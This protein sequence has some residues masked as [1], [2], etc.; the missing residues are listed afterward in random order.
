VA[1]LPFT[2]GPI[3]L[4]MSTFSSTACS[5][6]FCH[7]CADSRGLLHGLHL[8]S[9]APSNYQT[10][11]ARKHVGPTSTSTGLNSVLNS[12]STS[13]YDDLALSALQKGILEIEPNG[14]RSL[15]YQSTGNLGTCSDAGSPKEYLD[16][17]RWVLSSGSS[18][19]HGRPV[20]SREY[21]GHICSDCGSTLIT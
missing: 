16:S 13:E 10:E 15:V 12:G 3:R 18:L 4:T 1:F 8:T 2:L 9:T 14:S 17:F 19:A 6:F 11:K 20:S 7:A 21:L 5:T